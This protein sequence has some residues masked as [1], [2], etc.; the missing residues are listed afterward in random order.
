MLLVLPLLL[1]FL[2]PPS[3]P[4]SAAS[5]FFSSS[6]SSAATRF[7][8]VFAVRYS[9]RTVQGLAG[10]VQSQSLHFHGNL[11]K[12]V[13]RFALRFG[14]LPGIAPNEE[15][16]PSDQNAIGLGVLFYRHHELVLQ[17]IFRGPIVNDWDY[18]LI[19][20]RVIANPLEHFLVGNFEDF[21]FFRRIE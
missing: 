18:Q 1:A 8:G 20:V 17:R 14:L 9:V 4:P 19:I 10:R 7:F 21:G 13:E 12:I 16:V 11:E 2:A 6:S 15:P 3:S 5:S